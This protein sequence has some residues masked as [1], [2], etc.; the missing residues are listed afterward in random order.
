LAT[1]TRDTLVKASAPTLQVVS[2]NI[3]GVIHWHVFDLEV[4]WFVVT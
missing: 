3:K 1:E 2:K 4:L